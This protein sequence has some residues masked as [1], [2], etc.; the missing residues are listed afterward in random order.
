M[1]WADAQSADV[2]VPA[3]P[4]ARPDRSN[5]NAARS[6]STDCSRRRRRV[7]RLDRTDDA[8]RARARSRSA[9][10]CTSTPASAA[11]ATN[12]ARALD[13][14]RRSHIDG[15]DRMIIVCD[16][17]NVRSAAIPQRLGYTLERVEQRARPK[18]RARRGRMQI[19]VRRT[20]DRRRLRRER[21]RFLDTGHHVVVEA[22]WRPRAR[23]CS[24][25]PATP[26]SR[27]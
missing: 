17:A 14:R 5:A 24:R 4:A 6:G 21:N 16:E 23:P 13:R 3:R 15:I 2:D 8:P 11:Y 12:A 9:T 19:W 18:R 1:P 20:R 10:G 25:A 26:C 27:R 22:A 7:P